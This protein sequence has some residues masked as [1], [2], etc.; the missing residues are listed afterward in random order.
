MLSETNILGIMKYNKILCRY[1][2]TALKGDYT[3]MIFEDLLISNVSK[4]MKS[5]KIE[6]SFEKNPGRLFVKTDQVKKACEILQRTFGLTSI[7]PVKEIAIKS[8]IKKIVDYS[9]KLAKKFIE[10]KDTFAVRARR[11]GNDNFTSQTI[12]RKVGEKVIEI[13]GAKVDLD[14]PD[15]TLYIEVRQNKAYFFHERIEC[16]G[17]LPLGSQGKVLVLF[18]GGIDSPVAAWMM[19]KRGCEPIY[20]Y[21]DNSPFTT[22]KGLDRT[23][24]ALKELSRWSVGKE[25]QLLVAGS[26]KF[27]ED[28]KKNCEDRFTCILCKRMMYRIAEKIAIEKNT[29]AIVTGE[30]LGQVASQ[31]LDNINVLN[32]SIRTPILRPV[33]GLNKEEIIEMARKIGTYESST[34]ETGGCAAVP[35]SPRT[36]GRIE[37]ADREERKIDTQKLLEKTMK[38][39]KTFNI[40]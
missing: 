40:K 16:P 38:K 7:S 20:L 14:N 29:K 8:D 27:M 11:T 15:K 26:G 6:F 12:E 28:V 9:E 24:K 25:T 35:D 36:K 32:N 21:I 5:E 31:T 33:I 1:G 30:N 4:G 34:I 10:S 39:I 13:T 22:K 19:M 3:R 18:S 37:E 17:G 2:E 23:K